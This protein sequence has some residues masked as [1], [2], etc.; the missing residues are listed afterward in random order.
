MSI[1]QNRLR[2]F[3][4]TNCEVGYLAS[5]Y[6]IPVGCKSCG[7]AKSSHDP[8]A[9]EK[10]IQNTVR[11]PSSL[12]VMNKSALTVQQNRSEASGWNQ[13]SDRSASGV[14]VVRRRT[15]LQ[16]GSL[17]AG[18]TGVDV[19]HN[20]YDRYLARK[21]GKVALKSSES[22]YNIVQGCSC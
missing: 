5:Q 13:S 10:R 19:K 21:K 20:S 4:C 17:S 1:R 2:T 15:K 16:P 7:S 11:V 18:G 8:V 12:Y 3:G 14:S 22:K 6:Q 9:I